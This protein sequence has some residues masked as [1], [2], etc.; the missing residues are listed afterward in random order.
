MYNYRRPH[1]TDTR[2]IAYCPPGALLTRRLAASLAPWVTS[3]VVGKD[4]VPRMTV[5]TLRRLM[6]DM[7]TALARCTR[8]KLH[9]W[10]SAMGGWTTRDTRRLFCRYQDTP[11]EARQTLERY[12][13]SVSAQGKPLHLYPPGRVV[14]LAELKGTADGWEAVWAS[15]SEIIRE[16]ILISQRMYTDHLCETVRECYASADYMCPALPHIFMFS[17][18][19]IHPSHILARNTFARNTVV[20]QSIVDVLYPG[21]ASACR[22]PGLLRGGHRIQLIVLSFLVSST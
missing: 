14:F 16:G 11:D 21:G 4:I 3:V 20:D 5:A 12:L 7:V 13:V 18:A 8:H 17:H 10:A 22:V 15:P 6:D 19:S 1:L 9:V 2:C